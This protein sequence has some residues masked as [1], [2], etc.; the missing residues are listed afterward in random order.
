MPHPV[1]PHSTWGTNEIDAVLDAVSDRAIMLLDLSGTVVRWTAGGQA[2]LGYN[3]IDAVGQ[4]VSMFYTPEDRSAG[5]AEQELTAAL[6]AGRVEF[7]GWRIRQDGDQFRAT[8]T[9][10]TIGDQHNQVSGFVTVIRDLAA[11]QQRAQPMFSEMLEAAPDAM[12]IVGPDGRI[13]FANAQTDRLFGY[14]RAELIGKE[15]E[16]LLPTRFRDKHVGHRAD[17]HA[18]PVP[19]PMGRELP[20]WG[21]RSDGTEFPVDVSLSSLRIAHTQYVS[22]AIRDVTERHQY[23]QR[24]LYHQHELMKAQGELERLARIDSLTGLVNHAETIARLETALQDKR[25][26]GSDLG[27]LFCDADYFKEINDVWGHPL[28]DVVLATLAQR[29]R[30]CVRDGDTVGRIGGDEMLVLLPSVHSIHEVIGIAEKI[31][32]RVAEPIHHAGNTIRATVSI[33]A[34]LA[35]PGESVSTMT[36]RADAAMYTA[37]QTG[38]NAV[39]AI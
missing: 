38:R 19:R 22:A 17:F 9:I 20:L 36:A 35:I 6:A 1:A 39:T 10:N 27:V 13:T 23:E 8:V 33:G 3:A 4:H 24:L 34:T 16:I 12:V 2:L 5:L 31:R 29:I 18:N 21:R 26:P 15:V 37:K 25:V 14:P 28:G 30:N 11:D 32:R 7:E